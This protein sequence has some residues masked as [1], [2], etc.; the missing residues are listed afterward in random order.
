MKG[1]TPPG[2]A[3]LVLAT[4]NPERFSHWVRFLAEHGVSLV[5][6]ELERRALGEA[7]Q[8][9]SPQTVLLD[10]TDAGLQGANSRRLLRELCLTRAVGLIAVAR[11]EHLLAAG[12][13][14]YDD[15]IEA[16]AAPEEVLFRARSVEDRVRDR[17]PELSAGEITVRPDEGL[18]F[19]GDRRLALTRPEF[20][21]LCFL[22]AHPDRVFSRVHLAREVWG[23]EFEGRSRS[24][25][26]VVCR[27]RHRLGQYG[28]EHLK[29]VSRTGYVLRRPGQAEAV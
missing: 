29:T 4:G 23:Q 13:I 25:D 1:M 6:A 26:T 18:A 11:R 21:L 10:V 28:R 27:L 12:S 7:L 14:D 2:T 24:I 19:L 15:V 22:V 16:G 20:S 8:G 3:R 17:R 5:V 9:A